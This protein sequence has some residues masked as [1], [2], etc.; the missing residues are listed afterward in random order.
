MHNHYED[1]LER[2]AEL[3]AWFDDG[4][5]PRYGAFS[6][7]MLGNIYAQEAALAE[8][9]CQGCGQSFRVALSDAFAERHLGLGD[10]I[11]LRRV[12]YG[13]PPNVGCCPAG[14]T[15]NSVMHA[16]LEYWCKNYEISFE[17]VRD[18]AF[19]GPVAEGRL[20]PPDTLAAVLAALG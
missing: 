1:I 9:S 6:P 7:T 12:R 20:E 5:V 13:D 8:V 14:P 17:W 19:E 2:I 10:V 4:G 11:R 16:I 3:P 18:P 15:M